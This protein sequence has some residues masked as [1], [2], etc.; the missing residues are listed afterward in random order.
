MKEGTMA[1]LKHRLL[2]HQD[3][4]WPLPVAERRL[5]QYSS[6]YTGVEKTN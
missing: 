5:K 6:S 4:A 3:P 2:M 1:Y